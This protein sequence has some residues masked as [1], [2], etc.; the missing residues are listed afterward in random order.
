MK[1]TDSS[2]HV[3]RKSRW[4]ANGN[5]VEVASIGGD[6]VGVRDSKALDLPL[7]RVPRREWLAFIDH[8]K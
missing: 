2:G 8:I 3:W 5:C 1:T 4:S 7:L 6:Q